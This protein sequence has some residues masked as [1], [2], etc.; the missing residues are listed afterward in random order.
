MYLLHSHYGINRDTE[1]RLSR[2]TQLLIE[3]Q[4]KD[5]EEKLWQQWL[6]LYAKM[7]EDHFIDWI[8]YKN[9]CMK[10]LLKK[11]NVEKVLKDVK[12]ILKDVEEIKRLDQSTQ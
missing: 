2:I 9:S 5:I 3:A 8:D 7:D 1:I 4:N 11:V 6:V 12:E 10:P